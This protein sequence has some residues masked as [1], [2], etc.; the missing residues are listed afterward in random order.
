MRAAEVADSQPGI[1]EVLVVAAVVIAIVLAAAW[2]TAILPRDLQG[3]VFHTP[4]L[5]VVLLGGT[6]IVLWRILRPPG[7]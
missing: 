3:L 4:L 1:R 6:A 7:S 2:A 5:I